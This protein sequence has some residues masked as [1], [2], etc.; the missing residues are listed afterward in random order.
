MSIRDHSPITIE[1][2]NG[3]FRRGDFDSCPPDH[4][5]DC[6]NIS[7]IQSGFKSRDG[8]SP[9]LNIPNAVRVY[10]Y[11]KQ[12]GESLL[13][14]DSSGNIW[15]SNFF[16]GAPILTIVGMTDFGF[17][18]FDGRAYISPSDGSTGLDLA[19]YVYLGTGAPARTAAGL[20]PT[21]ADGALAAANSGTAGKI[22]AGIHI[23]GVVYETDT[24]FLTKIGPGTLPT[25]TAPGSQKVNLTAIPV[26]GASY[27]TKRHIVATKLIQ[28]AFYTGDTRGYQFFFVPD[29]VIPD[30]TATTLTVDFFD[31]EL[32]EDASYLLDVYE[33]IPAGV[34][35]GFYHNRLISW[36]EHDNPSVVRISDVGDPET[37]DTVDGLIIFPLDGRPITNCQEFRDVLYVFKST[38]TNAWTD[39]GD[40]PATWPMTI[41][42]QG[43]GTCLHGISTVLDS[44]GVNIEFI[45]LATFSG[46]YIFTGTYINP[47]LSWKIFDFWKA[48]DKTTFSKIQTVNDT[49]SKILYWVLPDGTMLIGDYSNGLGDKTIRWAPW[50]FSI[51]I[52][53]IAILNPET[54]ILIS[55]TGSVV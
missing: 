48:I 14:L 36:A 7:F 47:E 52:R 55:D 51:N 21:N 41:I 54:I 30:N 11:P 25:V 10:T 2:F 42:D 8:I 29:G 6:E 44:E 45:V 19:L 37:I 34:G 17:A 28:A 27:V 5:P 1:E 4:F 26:S 38:K 24:G 39:N 18:P 49:I 31:S 40:F 46:I 53:G 13:V 15:D 23:F 33:L 20:A 50:N 22:E 35:L 32:I 16:P 9:Y 12:T 3:L 43:I